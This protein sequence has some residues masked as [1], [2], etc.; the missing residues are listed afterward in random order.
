MTRRRLAALAALVLLGIAVP[1]AASASDGSVPAQVKVYVTDGSLVERLDDL[2]GLNESGTG[3]DFDETTKT[4]AISR[5]WVWTDERLTGAPTEHPVELTNNWVVPIALGDEPIGYATIWI[6][7]EIDAPELA[8]F[9]AEPQTAVVLGKIPDDAQLVRDDGSAAWFALE[10]GILTPLV[11][12]TSGLETPAPVEEVALVPPVA[13][14]PEPSTAS[15]G[16]LGLALAVLAGLVVVIAVSLYLSRRRG[17]DEP[18]GAERSEH[19][20][21]ADDLSSPPA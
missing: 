4:G 10:D 7:P 13:A 18:V 15:G 14:D 3:I 9:T 5:V 11:P 6:N 2:Y 8:E 17:R 20:S 12:G 19:P 21:A 16:G 1:A